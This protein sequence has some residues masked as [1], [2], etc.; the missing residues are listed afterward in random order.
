M[1]LDGVPPSWP[2]GTRVVEYAPDA[3]ELSRMIAAWRRAR[4]A[5]MEGVAWYR[6]PVGAGKRN[7]RW[8]TFAAVMDGREPIHRLE[9][10]SAGENPT[11]LRL[12]NDGEAEENLDVAVRIRWEG[13]Q[14]PVAEALRGWTVSLSEH[15]ALFSRTD[16]IVP[17]LLPGGRRDIGWLRFDQPYSTH[18]EILR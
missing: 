3:T 9:V 13:Q 1:W 10:Q 17:R 11:D 12:A 4:P 2:A 6:L 8:P 7:W 16:T 5:G 14:K 15:E 18:A